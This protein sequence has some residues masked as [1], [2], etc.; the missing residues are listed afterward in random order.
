[1]ACDVAAYSVDP[2]A[3]NRYGPRGGTELDDLR[4]RLLVRIQ[5]VGRG[6]PDVNIGSTGEFGQAAVSNPSCRPERASGIL[7]EPALPLIISRSGTIGPAIRRGEPRFEVF[8]SL[9]Q[10]CRHCLSRHCLKGVQSRLRPRVSGADRLR[11]CASAAASQGPAGSGVGLLEVR[12][13]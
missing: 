8:R 7:A 1:M 9:L 4:Y 6:N 11:G 10:G 12:V 5:L 3:T 13:R 2:V